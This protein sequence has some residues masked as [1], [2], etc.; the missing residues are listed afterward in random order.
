MRHDETMPVV[1]HVARREALRAVND[2]RTITA[3]VMGFLLRDVIKPV[4]GS[5]VRG[6]RLDTAGFRR[7][8]EAVR[9]GLGSAS[10]GALEERF[11]APTR[12][13]PKGEAHEILAMVPTGT[14][15]Q[16]DGHEVIGQMGVRI[17]VTRR[18][19]EFDSTSICT[20]STRHLVERAVQRGMTPWTG[21]HR[22]VS[23]AMWSGLGLTAVWRHAVA[24][25]LVPTRETALPFGDGLMVG[26]MSPNPDPPS[27]LKV[28]VNALGFRGLS[29]TGDG[30]LSVPGIDPA[31]EAWL[32]TFVTVLD[33]SRLNPARVRLHALLDDFARDNAAALADVVRATAWPHAEDASPRAA[34]EAALPALAAS[35]AT[36]LLQPDV[37][38][39]LREREGD[40]GLPIAPVPARP[41]PDGW[42]ADRLA[43]VWGIEPPDKRPQISSGKF[44]ASSMR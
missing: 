25:G 44:P 16:A 11:T 32:T 35:L 14:G 12:T 3:D 42:F 19:L 23:Q 15:T 33:W 18:K 43:K 9:A 24:T 29:E 41:E 30:H 34:A 2:G 36:G 17:R 1:D 27:R 40:T 10:H 28:E 26:S 4:A 5:F 37:A 20:M 13:R 22:E 39:A 31:G 38:P 7:T 21:V 6:D 8:V